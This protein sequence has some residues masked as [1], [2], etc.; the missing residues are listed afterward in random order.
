MKRKILF[1]LVLLVISLCLVYIFTPNFTYIYDRVKGMI[2]SGSVK[3][4]VESSKTFLEMW[5]SFTS[6]VGNFFNSLGHA[7]TS[8]SNLWSG[9]CNAFKAI[10]KFISNFLLYAVFVIQFIDIMWIL[11]AMY[12]NGQNPSYKT[13]FMA[14]KIIGLCNRLNAFAVNFKQ[15]IKNFWNEYKKEIIILSIILFFAS[16]YGSIIIFE[17]GVYIVKYVI[18]L[19][20]FTS[21]KFLFSLIKL[22]VVLVIKFIKFNSI[23]ENIIIGLIVFYFVA[24]SLSKKKLRKNKNHRLAL[25]ACETG[26]LNLVTGKPS[27]GKSLSITTFSLDAEELFIQDLEEALLQV[28]AD[29]PLFNAALFHLKCRMIFNLV[30]KEEMDDIVKSYPGIIKE[31]DDLYNKLEPLF[32]RDD[33]FIDTFYRLFVRGCMISSSSG[34]VEPYYEENDEITYSHALDYDSLRWYQKDMKLYHEPY[35]VLT[36]YEMD[37]EFNSHDSRGEVSDDGTSAFFAMLSHICKRHV[38][39][40][41]DYQSKDQLIKRIRDVSEIIIRIDNKQYK[42]PFWIS[43]LRRPVVS[44]DNF[45]HRLIRDYRS[46]KKPVEKHSMRYKPMTIKR[47]DVNVMY[48]IIKGTANLFDKLYSYFDNFQYIKFTGTFTYDD[49]FD[50]GDLLKWSINICELSHRGSKLYESCQYFNFFQEIKSKKE[51]QSLNLE[52]I[53]SW[54]S[55]SPG[56]EFYNKNV[57]QHFNDK[58]INAQFNKDDSSSTNGGDFDLYGF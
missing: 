15:F 57:H 4:P 42:Y 18:S 36:M 9:I 1:I 55:L 53:P 8:W 28:E 47:N 32:L 33:G 50:H 37:K 31:C 49:N 44:V 29:Y 17:A 38:K 5:K 54:P 27:A 11:L 52:N 20:T 21:H 12:F 40:F 35:E 43:L 30:S 3:D 6:G 51:Q 48:L 46:S 41:G 25:V 58:L 45:C 10:F 26:V 23:F 24:I 14:R 19:V 39:V 13:S 7:F 56:F 16:G 2:S 22:V 34:I